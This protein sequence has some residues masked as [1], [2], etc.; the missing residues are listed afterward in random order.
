MKKRIIAAIMAMTMSLSLVACTGAEPVM[1]EPATEEAFVEATAE[2]TVEE[3][4]DA[5]SSEESVEAAAEE[6]TVDEENAI[7]ALGKVNGDVYENEY[8]NVKVELADGYTFADEETLATV[9]GVATDILKENDNEAVAKQ[10][11]S[12]NLQ[13]VALGYNETGCNINVGVQQNALLSNVL[14][15]EKQ[16]LEMSVDSVKEALEAQGITI[17]STELV[18]EEVAGETHTVLKLHG[19]IQG[20]EYH[21]AMVYFERGS[22]L[23]AIT[24]TSFIEDQSDVM[25][26]KVSAL[27]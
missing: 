25:L 14:F 27:N 13:I 24:A 15:D 3:S 8:F 20:I 2:A 6:A 10:L 21:G 11:E 18:E 16:M 23:L 9:Y 22:Y 1:T 4:A 12:G 26:S 19:E 7:P 5:A 17:S